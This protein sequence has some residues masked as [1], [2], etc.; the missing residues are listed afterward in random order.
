MKHQPKKT[1]TTNTSQTTFPSLSACSSATGIPIALL[2]QAKREGCPAFDAS[3]RIRLFPLLQW[4]FAQDRQALE[5]TDWHQRWK[6][7]QAETAE[8]ELAIRRGKLIERAWM[9]ER[10]QVAAGVLNAFRVKSELE[11]PTRFAATGGD[12]AKCRE[13]LCGIWDEIMRGFQSLASNFKE[14]TATP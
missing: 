12:V 5:N 3:N 14:P 4:I 2:R 11:H 6:R 1:P 7:A 10:I 8:A 13:H 9:A